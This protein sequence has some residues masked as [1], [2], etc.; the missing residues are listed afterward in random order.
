MFFMERNQAQKDKKK[1][2]ALCFT[3]PFSIPGGGG[4]HGYFLGGYLPPG[5]PKLYPVLENA[6]EMDTPF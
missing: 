1:I 5:T 4:A 2:V 3:P 6:S